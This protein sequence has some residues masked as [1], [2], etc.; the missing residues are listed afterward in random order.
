M[1]TIQAPSEVGPIRVADPE[2]HRLEVR[3]FIR[4]AVGFSAIGFLIYF[5]LYGASEWLVREHAQRN[6]FHVVQSAP[7][8]EYDVVLLGASHA[9]ALDYRDM[10]ARLEAMSGASVLN[11]ATVGAGVTVNRLL[12]DYFFTRRSARTVVYVLDSFGFYSAEWNEER[13]K[14]ASL[15]VRAPWDPALARLLLGRS[16]TRSVALAY[17][18]GFPKINNADRFEPDLF[19]DEG[20]RF[21][22]VYRPVAQIDRQRIEYL[23]GGVGPNSALESPYLVELESMI[24]EVHARDARFV[25]V[26][27]P[28]PARFKSS[29][30][31]ETEF[32]AIV[33]D[34]VA[35]TGAELYD[36]SEVAN[37][38]EYFYDSDHLNEAGVLNFFEHHLSRVLT[39]GAAAPAPALSDSDPASEEDVGS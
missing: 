23:Y 18:S 30:P 15:Y 35:R 9:A 25:L 16:G 1:S 6:R 27:P 14:D 22:R 31:H 39:A 37:D 11:L 26:R 20:P 38:P 32:D 21:D 5:A 33:R 8:A 28:I 17:V 4:R 10:N 7:L 34:L 36:F 29:I 2:Q 12:L 19:A 13:L 24:A 3:T